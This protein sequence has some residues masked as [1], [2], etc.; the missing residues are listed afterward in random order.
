MGAEFRFNNDLL[1]SEQDRRTAD[2]AYH[3]IFFALDNPDL[4]ALFAPRDDAANAAKARSRRRGI[5]AVLVVTLALLITASVPLFETAPV[6]IRETLALL[7]AAIGVVGGGLGLNGVLFGEAKREWLRNR[8]TTERLRQLHFQTLL[9]FAPLVLKAAET[10]DTA[11][12][13]KARAA[14]LA[15]FESE[16]VAHLDA[17]LASVL[18]REVGEEPWLLDVAFNATAAAGEHADLFLEAMAH[19][20]INHQI[21]FAEYKLSSDEKLFSTLPF[22]Q[23]RIIDGAALGCVLLL[24]SLDVLVLAGVAAGAAPPL[25]TLAHVGAISFAI[26]ALALRTLE[27]GLQPHREVERYRQYGSALRII[28]DRFQTAATANEKMLALKGLEDLTYWEMVSFLK[29]NDE[30]RFVM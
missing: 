15:R 14:A 13:L 24:L 18:H 28:R 29:S 23:I 7:G 21:D 6:Q 2:T 1:R 17:K 19:L 16:Q 12:F 27:E 10:G 5:E 3:E 11:P 22:R 9:A 8:F 26:I 30:A 4:R 25:L 20:R